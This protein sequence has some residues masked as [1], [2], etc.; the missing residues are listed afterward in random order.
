MGLN[1]QNPGQYTGRHDRRP[2]SASRG[3]DLNSRLTQEP[4]NG[5]SLAPA[6]A[7]CGAL[8]R[9]S[10]RP[11]PRYPVPYQVTDSPSGISTQGYYAS[12]QD[13]PKDELFSKNAA[14]H[15]R[16]RQTGCNPGAQSSRS[17]DFSSSADPTVING[18]DG[19]NFLDSVNGYVPPDTDI[20][21]GP[22]SSSRPSTHRSSSMTR[23]PGGDAAQHAAEPVLRSARRESLRPRRDLRRHRRPVHRGRLHVQQSSCSLPSPR[24]SNPFDG[25]SSYDLDVSEG[26]FR[27][28]LPQD[29]LQ[30]RRSGDQLNMYPGPG[31]FPRPGSLVRRQLAFSPTPPSSPLAPTISLTTGSDNDFTMARGVDARRHRRHADVLRRGERLR[32]WR[33]DAGVSATDL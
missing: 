3:H 9:V 27:A 6:D 11:V 30:C 16:P 12:H 1:T 15:E 4:A 32:Q 21:V 28:R 5:H 20:A 14:G 19:M 31:R 13:N 17:P 8:P 24:P 29:W 25:F 7:A 10:H 22:S 33:N 18:F 23:P 26:G 2:G